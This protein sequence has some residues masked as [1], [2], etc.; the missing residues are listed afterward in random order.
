MLSEDWKTA[1]GPHFGIITA[2]S[3][4]VAIGVA[5]MIAGH[6]ANMHQAAVVSSQ[7]PAAAANEVR[8]RV[9]RH[10]RTD[11]L[12]VAKPR[13]ERKSD[14]LSE[15]KSIHFL[16]APALSEPLPVG[17]PQE[18]APWLNDEVDLEW[19]LTPVDFTPSPGSRVA[20]GDSGRSLKGAM[21]RAASLQ[22]SATAVD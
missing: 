5:A 3:L 4:A 22:G 16:F 13:A 21:S 6:L 18:L 14:R 10:A 2:S 7:P 12:E 11:R 1:S 17:K 20:V 9:V 8:Q 15:S 19:L